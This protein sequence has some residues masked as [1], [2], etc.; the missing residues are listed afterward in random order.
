MALAKS[1]IDI[2]FDYTFHTPKDALRSP[3]CVKQ[4][5][6]LIKKNLELI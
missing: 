6:E 1:Q 5:V 2:L 3:D 4:R